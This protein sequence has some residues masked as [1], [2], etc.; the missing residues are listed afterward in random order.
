M[1]LDGRNNT[2]NGYNSTVT[3]WNDLSGNN[4]N[5]TI[6]GAIWDDNGLSFDGED[7]VVFLGQINSNYLTYEA[8]FSINEI[9]ANRNNVLGNYNA[10]GA[11]IFISGSGK[12][13]GQLYINSAWQTI[14]TDYFV[15]LGK[16]YVAQLTYDGN[17]MILYVDGL[18]ISEQVLLVFQLTIRL[19]Q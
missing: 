1:Q 13:S 4:N 6:N 11:E 10:G 18:K 2:G 14:T 7:D 5:G 16:I 12:I 3:T 17:K 19:L 8:Q 15:E 9:K